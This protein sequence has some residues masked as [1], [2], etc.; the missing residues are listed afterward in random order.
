MKRLQTEATQTVDKIIDA[1]SVK[2]E[3]NLSGIE[4]IFDHFEHDQ[5]NE[6]SVLIDDLNTH[7]QRI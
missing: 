2:T 4:K 1:F 7:F 6:S 3:E 5:N